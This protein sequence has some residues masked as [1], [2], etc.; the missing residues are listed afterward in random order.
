MINVDNFKMKTKLFYFSGTGN[1]LKVAKDLAAE[2]GDTDIISI[3]KVMN[4]E[5]NL[6]CDR[7]GII[8]PTYMFGIPLI[9]E[10]FLK[11]LS[12]PK[13][14]FTV[15]TAGGNPGFSNTQA[16]KI[17]ADN[18]SNLA[19]GFFVKMP[20]NYTPFGTWSEDKQKKAFI[21][22]KGKVKHIAEIINSGSKGT[23]ENGNFL[24][25]WL[26]PIIYK[27]AAPK[28]PTMDQNFWVTD[29][30]IKCGNCVNMCPVGDIEL[31]D[32]KPRWKGHCEQCF[33]C[34]QWCPIHCIEYKKSTKGKKR[35]HHPDIK[36]KELS[37]KENF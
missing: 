28:I 2:L 7:I 30:C 22:A 4:S 25:K 16:K 5:I 20:S 13:Y 36:A 1:S 24:M 32:G 23:L 9:V 3:S 26:Y 33:A 18:N 17:L 29:K 31:Y 11:R 19:N 34:L 21:E 8:F 6:D 37:M 14:V 10:R 15:V 12:T 35:Y 27:F